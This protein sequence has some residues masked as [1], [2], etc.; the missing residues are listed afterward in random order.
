MDEPTS[1]VDP[2]TEKL[3]YS[4]MFET[5]G[6]KA[7]I[8]SLHRLHLLTQFDYIYIMRNGHVVDEGTFDHLNRC[9]LAFQE[10]WIHQRID[11][12][13]EPA[14]YPSLNVAL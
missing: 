10:M 6:Q 13:Q 3:I 5:F 8:S 9:S 12:P 11:T 7:V 1:S 2:R 14:A 4:R